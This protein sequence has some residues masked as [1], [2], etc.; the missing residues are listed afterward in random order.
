L[1]TELTGAISRKLTPHRAHVVAL[2]SFGAP[3]C[4]QNIR[5]SIGYELYLDPIH[6][7]EEPITD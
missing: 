7:L 2:S 1:G 5:A 6:T 3:Q 4:R